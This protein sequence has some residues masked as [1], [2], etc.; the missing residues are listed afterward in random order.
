MRFVSGRLKLDVKFND[1]TDQYQVKIC[2]LYPPATAHARRTMPKCETIKVGQPGAGPR[3]AHGRRL[4]VDD[5]RAMKSAAHAAI[6][7]AS[8]DIQNYADSNRRGSGWLVKPPKRR[9]KR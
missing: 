9:R 1:R 5:P 6:S 4:A 3:S 8:D 2:P 7:F